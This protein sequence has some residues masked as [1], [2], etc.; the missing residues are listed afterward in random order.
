MKCPKCGCG[1]KKDTFCPYC[2]ITADQV[3]FASN[4]EAKKRI[5]Q[6]DTDEVYTSSYIP[7]DVSKTKLF[8]ITLFGGALGFDAY[9]LGRYKRGIIQFAVFILTFMLFVLSRVLGYKALIGVTDFFG[10]ACVVF[11]FLWI[12][13]VFRV[14]FNKATVPIVLPNAEELDSRRQAYEDMLKAKAE[15]R[16]VKQNKK[17]DKMVEKEKKNLDKKEKKTKSD[18]K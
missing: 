15:A 5:K 16:E 2:K 18:E 6:K 9:Y 3:K 11:I 10:I 1:I 4:V 13:N 17:Y 12:G 14:L 7:Y 8:F